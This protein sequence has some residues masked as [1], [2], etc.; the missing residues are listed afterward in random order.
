MTEETT[1]QDFD[2]FDAIMEAI[3]KYDEAYEELINTEG[4]DELIARE[5]RFVQTPAETEGEVAQV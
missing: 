5:A 2:E 3:Q 1:Q 4:F